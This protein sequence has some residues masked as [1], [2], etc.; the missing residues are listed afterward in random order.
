[1]WPAWESPGPVRPRTSPS[2]RGAQRSL[3]GLCLRPPGR[4]GMLE[5]VGGVLRELIGGS[6][7]C[8]GS[9]L[10]GGAAI[11]S[12]THS[13]SW[14]I[15]LRQTEDWVEWRGW[16]WWWLGL[17]RDDEGKLEKLF[18]GVLQT[19]LVIVISQWSWF[20]LQNV[21]KVSL[22]K[23]KQVSRPAIIW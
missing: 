17:L 4:R 1:M 20:K 8:N 18:V 10:S 23:W 5:G 15:K 12:C 7:L 2:R 22:F 14:K 3:G 16:W 11:T 9:S 21:T 13:V 19:H 6:S